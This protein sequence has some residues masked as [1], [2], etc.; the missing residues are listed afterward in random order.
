M[1]NDAAFAD[2]T[3][4]L[5]RAHALGAIAELLGWDEQVNLPP[6]GAEQRGAQQ[7]ALAEAI[8]A[9]ASDRAIGEL[10]TVLE[11][12]AGELTA[13]QRVVVAH[14][15]KDYDRATKLPVE[16]VREK[17][18]QGSRGYHAWVRA[19]AADDF[20]G[21]VPVLEKNLELAKREA[22]YLGWGG[23]EYDYL[24]DK[25]DPG[26]TAATV[27]RLFGELKRALVPLVREITGS[28]TAERA[29]AAAAALRGCPVEAQQR[30][31]REVT[32][33]I[34]F[35]YTRGRIDVS[36]H[37]FCS[38][39]GS[40]VR[41]TT[42]FKV[43]EPLDSLFAS[44][45][46]TGHGLYEQGLPAAHLGTALGLHAGMAVHES[47]S[48]L[49]ENQVARSRGFWRGCEPRFRA[50]FPAQTAGVSAEE[51]YLA[52][53]AVEPTQIR[54]EADEVTYNLHIILRFELEKKLF[55]GELAV[56]DLPAA[57]RAAAKEIVGLEPATDREGV[58]QDVHWSDG[59]FG[60][61]PSYC[62]G[63]ML[64]AQLW[65]RALAVRPELEEDFAR[66]DFSW[67]L[68]WL[69]TEVHAQGR[70]FD[71][72]ALARRVTGEALSPQAL[73]RYL[74]ERYGA[75]YQA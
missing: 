50:L 32:E 12:K 47:Q 66:G 57:W 46:E 58:L 11:A 20:A 70:R 24:L 6:G 26:L 25:H 29:R 39:T 5:Q 34:G 41:M 36:L 45:H 64:A 28:P 63:N 69:R 65:Y 51:F 30:F 16:F 52:V 61:F 27:E 56:R 74:R 72:L 73:V 35:D 62:L 75:L 55:T 14:A 49:W 17:A 2:L 37:P 8:H 54:V 48:R 9:A 43:D 53:N 18:A 10:L 23:R 19:K 22:G 42:R 44:I 40:D 67:L 13:D 21:Y 59:A 7:A 15:R 38:G 71:A 31:L 68:G 1:T 4:R 33:R 60:Y 3:T